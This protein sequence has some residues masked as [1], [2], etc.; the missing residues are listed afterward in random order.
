VPQDNDTYVIHKKGMTDTVNNNIELI[1]WFRRWDDWS[2]DELGVPDNAD[3]SMLI[4]GWRE[5]RRKQELP[6]G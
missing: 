5:E 4:D 6:Q 3:R 2:E 1:Q